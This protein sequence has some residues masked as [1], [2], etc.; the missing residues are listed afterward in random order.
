MACAVATPLPEPMDDF[1][2]WLEAQGV[3]EEVARA[4][5][6]EL[7]I[8]DYGV[9]RACVGDGLVRAELL[10]AARDRLPFGFYAVLR[11]VVKALRGAE[12][13]HDGA[14]TPLWDDDDAAAAS[15]PGDVTLGGLVDVLLA[16]FSGLSRELLLSARRL[17]AMD[18]QV[19]SAGGSTPPGTEVEIEDLLKANGNQPSGNDAAEVSP[20]VGGFS[21]SQA[22]RVIKME[23]RDDDISWPAPGGD[24]NLHQ[25]SW[26]D[27]DPRRMG[28]I[29]STELAGKHIGDQSGFVIQKVT[30]L[31]AAG[32]DFSIDSSPRLLHPPAEAKYS[33]GG[34]GTRSKAAIAAA[35]AEHANQLFGDGSFRWPGGPN[36]NKIVTA[37]DGDRPA[38]ERVPPESNRRDG[39][40]GRPGVAPAGQATGH[41]S[42]GPHRCEVC[43]RCFAQRRALQSH[44]LAHTAGA[45]QPDRRGACGRALPQ[46]RGPNLDECA[47]AADAAAAA[48]AR[49]HR[50]PVCGRAFALAG[51]LKSHART[52]TGEKPYPCSVCGRA[53]S[54]LSSLKIHRSSHTRERPFRC[55]ACGQSFP[56]RCGL[57]RHERT[58]TGDKPHGCDECGRTF[59]LPSE[60]RN[61]RRTH[62][63]ERPFSCGVCGR[64][65]T[66]SK[67]LKMHE[68]THAREAGAAEGTPGPSGLAL[69]AGAGDMGARQPKVIAFNET[70]I[71]SMACA[72]ATP[73]LEPMDDFP[74]WL[75]AQGV[76]EE[77]AR[78]MDSELGI[79]DYGV[80]RACVGD[81]L[82]RAELLAAARDRLPFG[83]Y[84]VLRQVVKALRGAETHDDDDDAAACSPGDVTLG[85][86]VDAL[87][88]LFSG[89]S[90]E[91]L[92]CVGRLGE[93]DGLTHP[94]ALSAT[95]ADSPEDVG[96]GAMDDQ[97][98]SDGDFT[99]TA[100]AVAPMDAADDFVACPAE[101]EAGAGQLLSGERLN[102]NK[103]LTVIKVETSEEEKWN[104]VADFEG[105][106]PGQMLQR[107]KTETRGGT[108]SSHERWQ[109][110]AADA[111]SL[112]DAQAADV[113]AVGS[114]PA[115]RRRPTFGR[116]RVGNATAT[117]SG[118]AFETDQQQL[119]MGYAQDEKAADIDVPLPQEEQQQHQHHD[120]FAFAVDGLSPAFEP[121]RRRSLK[122]AAG[123]K[124]FGCRVCGHFF[125]MRCSLVRH[126]RLHTGEKPYSCSV[127]NHLFSSSSHLKSHERTHTGE[128]PYRCEVC[129]QNFSQLSTLRRHELTHTG[130]RPYRCGECEQTFTRKNVLRK[131]ERTHDSKRPFHCGGCGQSFG[132][133]SSL[134]FHQRTQVACS[135][136]GDLN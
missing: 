131:H 47:A 85:G 79:R 19:A 117:T 39:Y 82:V 81:G 60:L 129:K 94:T 29:S 4:M 122:V 58:H 75:E 50:C 103:T 3:N 127:C 113:P 15:S 107:V 28:F 25:V 6:S 9:L 76:N 8:R 33:G 63:G 102:H 27:L 88:A 38:T 66:W 110:V 54:W 118:G 30:S 95:G 77:V 12:P 24:G 21:P 97:E 36:H 78:A 34:G 72:V 57:K 86:L 134:K 136:V 65:F 17:G 48:A 20:P 69:P 124:L 52:H 31:Q 44:R 91:L 80:L 53:F 59:V 68:R 67:S 123:K 126:Q 84:A 2:A 125:S 135:Q 64:A 22:T 13:H 119:A 7:G 116:T 87:L 10:A 46:G 128:R 90:R 108:K 132:K 92:L 121:I 51:E 45:K 62:T 109:P 112:R 106:D 55:A 49:P 5:D 130:E 114:L 115:Q 1:P 105:L 14:G 70:S 71:I 99:S 40:A 16:L 111:S 41:P 23:L 98:T 11:Q 43:G 18:G 56:H 32:D 37:G 42:D 120:D 61:H 93:W 133:A 100:R 73:L 74:A 96:L 26:E 89:L 101:G 104:P 83:F 35:A